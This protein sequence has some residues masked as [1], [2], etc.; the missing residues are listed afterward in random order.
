MPYRRKNLRNSIPSITK[1]CKRPN[2]P[3]EVDS[4]RSAKRQRCVS[5]AVT[6]LDLPDDVLVKIF[7]FMQSPASGSSQPYSARYL[8]SLRESFTVA[9]TCTRLMSVF[10]RTL[11]SIDAQQPVSLSSRG[12]QLPV[13]ASPP[14]LTHVVTLAA[15]SLAVL[16]LPRFFFPRS[17]TKARQ[18][19]KAVGQHCPSIRELSFA[20]Q[21]LLNSE[22]LAS[23]LA[24]SKLQKV[25]ISSPG[26]KIL[27]AL[28]LSTSRLRDITLLDVEGPSITELEGL[29]EKNV[30]SLVQVKIGLDKPLVDLLS[31]FHEVDSNTTR[32]FLMFLSDLASSHMPLLEVLDIDIFM[33]TPPEELYERICAEL[34]ERMFQA[35]GIY[36]CHSRN[37][38]NAEAKSQLKKLRIH[39]LQCRVSQYLEV[40]QLLLVKSAAV[41]IE[42]PGA[43]VV[44]PTI[45]SG[46]EPY[47]R[48]LQL[49][50][51]LLN[52]RESYS[53]ML[54][55]IERLEVSSADFD[56][57]LRR[58][59]VYWVISRAEIPIREVSIRC[60]RGLSEEIWDSRLLPWRCLTFILSF[61]PQVK[62][63]S[64]PSE[65]FINYDAGFLQGMLTRCRY[66]EV[67][68]IYDSGFTMIDAFTGER[69]QKTWPLIQGLLWLLRMVAM[70]CPGL[71][72]LYLEEA[73]NFRDSVSR[74]M[75]KNTLCE[76]LGAVDRLES[77]LPL[78]DA[79]SVR[80]QLERW[81]KP[82]Y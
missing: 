9:E 6:I 81:M 20:D 3:F 63:L 25:E 54:G 37:V 34:L 2:V 24:G 28:R 79:G 52:F 71:K 5:Q 13:C 19:L 55:R 30:S 45:D 58:G 48:S 78:L 18:L 68:H 7:Q 69:R 53:S 31:P 70:C 65:V 76:A 26:V 22:C 61:A 66:L 47:L 41:E 44:F 8:L 62:T 23:S 36:L 57:L 39:G 15:E 35:I 80:A 67:L 17:K 59:E 1:R 14:H 40:M 43:A 64:I 74:K 73:G 16:R 46:T 11:S 49:S 82:P 38:K 60:R 72:S 32:S 10:G 77:R 42:C 12:S 56:I 33:S 51:S 75:L 50:N 21:G 29:L 27:K 4:S